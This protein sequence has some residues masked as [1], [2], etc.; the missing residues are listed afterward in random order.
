LLLLSLLLLIGLTVTSGGAQQQVEVVISFT[1]VCEE[2]SITIQQI[3]LAAGRSIDISFLTLQI[4]PGETVDFTRQ[5]AFTPERMGLQGTFDGQSFSL[6][7]DPLPIGTPFR[8]QGEVGGCLE[9]L[10]VVSGGEQPPTPPPGEKPIAPGQSLEQVIEV[11]QAMGINVRQE[12]S[13]TS[14]KLPN[15]D[16]PML[17]RAIAGLSAQ[18]LW[19]SAPGSLR[20]VISWD[21]PAVDLDLIVFA[22]PFGF[23]F[24]LN[25]A[26]LLAEI[27]DR[28]PFGPVPGAVFAVLIIN[29]SLTPQAYVL[30]L[31]P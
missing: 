2:I 21:N 31:S 1:N 19:V 25:P 26:G 14:P 18:L 29:W 6:T 30:A 12:G 5:L 16:D 23:C 4:N 15:V 24:Q 28:P 7:V 10:V 13:Q 20:S 22:F 9:M 11:L 3:V 8:D 27:C 17:L